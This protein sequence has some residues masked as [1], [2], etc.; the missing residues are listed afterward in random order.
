MLCSGGV[1]LDRHAVVHL[2][3]A[4]DLRIPAVTAEFVILAHDERLDRFG[5]ADLRAQAAEAAAGKI[6]VE[7][8]EDLNL[9][10]RLAVTAE[11]DQVIRA[12][13]GALVADDAGLGA[14]GGLDLQAQ[15]SAKARRCRTALSRILKRERRLRRVL[16]GQPQTL[17][18][19]DQKDRLEESDDRLHGYA[20]SPMTNVGSLWPD[21]M[22][23][24]F[25]STVPSLRILSCRRI[26]P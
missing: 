15:D 16:Q 24:S 26:S 19:I 23:R 11:G 12:R 3:D 4:K 13:L 22:M 18:Q 8:V 5:R 17:Q 20:L 7:V 25:R 1:L 6:E 9:L 2:I 14:G 21:M 10:P